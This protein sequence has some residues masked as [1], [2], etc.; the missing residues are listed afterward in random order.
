MREVG[1]MPVRFEAHFRVLCCWF[2]EQRG[3]H[4]FEMAVE[5]REGVGVDDAMYS[6]RIDRPE[7]T[8]LAAERCMDQ[9]RNVGQVEVNIFGTC[10]K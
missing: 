4:A 9:K 3:R 10:T 7:Q 5:E 1:L 6:M 8:H 2:I